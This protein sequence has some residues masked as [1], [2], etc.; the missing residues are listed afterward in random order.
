MVVAAI[1]Y[2]FFPQRRLAVCWNVSGVEFAFFSSCN[3]G[4]SGY[5]LGWWWAIA[6]Y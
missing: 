1:I 2:P 6:M 3:L 5:L 4:L